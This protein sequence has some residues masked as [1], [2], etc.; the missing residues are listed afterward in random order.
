M[1]KEKDQTQ[2]TT[3]SRRSFLKGVGTG[4]VAAS[5]APNVLIGAETAAEAQMGEEITRAK[6]KLNINNKAYEVEVEP[7]TTLL[8][9]LR[10]GFDTSGNRLDLTGAKPIC[11]RGECGGCTVQVDGK[12]VYACMM[13]ALD[14]QGKQI[15][16]VEGLAN[17]DQLHPVQ[18][19]FVQ[20]DALMCG[21]CTP[22]FVV[23]AKSFLDQNPS[24]SHEEIKEGL[25]GN[26]CR[27]GTYPFIF[28]AVKTASRKMGG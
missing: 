18:E 2:D 26:I 14:A 1:S 3:I 25:A 19:A 20:H 10:D 4:A 28:E 7:R 23:A 21:F 11:E 15:T 8:S 5:V 9:V 24:P 12:V 13:L 17:G 27:C 16:T 22:G 6:I